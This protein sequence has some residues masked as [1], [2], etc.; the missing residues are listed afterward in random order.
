MTPL[1]LSRSTMAL[2]QRNAATGRG[3]AQGALALRQRS[4]SVEARRVE[5]IRTAAARQ[6]QRRPTKAFEKHK[7]SGLGNG[8]GHDGVGR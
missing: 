5:R 3:D 1:L 4:S 6:Q 7:E 8:E 2:A